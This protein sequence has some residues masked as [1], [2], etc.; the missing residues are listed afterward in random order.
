MISTMSERRA[1][2][3]EPSVSQHASAKPWGLLAL[4]LP[5]GLAVCGG[6]VLDVPGHLKGV[7]KANLNWATGEP[8]DLLFGMATCHIC[9]EVVLSSSGPQLCMFSALSG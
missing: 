8:V 3:I 9:N 6:A 1:S 7:A 5:L 2:S 4:E